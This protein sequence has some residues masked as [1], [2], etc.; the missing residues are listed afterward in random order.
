[1]IIHQGHHFALRVL[2]HEHVSAFAAPPTC[3][4]GSQAALLRAAAARQH[5]WY[6]RCATGGS[7]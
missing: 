4:C 3:Q 1:M 2:E 5:A 6:W 7:S